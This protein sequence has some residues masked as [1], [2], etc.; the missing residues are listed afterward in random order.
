[1]S[2]E[3]RRLSR[4]ARSLEDRIQRIG[5]RLP[6]DDNLKAM[7]A[8]LPEHWRQ[9]KLPPMPELPA[10][11]NLKNQIKALEGLPGEIET[12]IASLATELGALRESLGDFATLPDAYA[13][14]IDAI[15]PRVEAIMSG[16]ENASDNLLETVPD[17]LGQTTAEV[18]E[19]M[20]QDL[21]Q[22]G[23]NLMEEVAEMLTDA[24]EDIG[25][26][27]GRGA[28]ALRAVAEE[29][30]ET[31]TNKLSETLEEEVRG[32]VA[33]L[34]DEVVEQTLMNL[35]Q[36]LGITQISAQVTAALSAQLPQLVV[37][38]QAVSAVR[39]MLEIMR[40]GF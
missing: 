35:A 23:K 36:S 39:R 11:A 2:P 10:L 25:E 13:A 21:E 34:G 5:V 20:E 37:A 12:S 22:A 8:P 9:P 6:D 40:A 31:L 14:L 3:R 32:S 33:Q 18:L 38:K 1:M 28:E 24:F 4:A 7:T 30:L 16:I 26:Q 19:K 27:A 29:M 15:E 17:A